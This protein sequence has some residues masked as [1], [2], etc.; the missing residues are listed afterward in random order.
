M[1][2]NV[3]GTCLV[4][5]EGSLGEDGRPKKS[6]M[7][8]VTKMCRDGTIKSAFKVGKRWFTDIEAERGMADG[9]D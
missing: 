6:H 9:D 1:V 5:F 7:N 4:F 8:T 2:R 3:Y